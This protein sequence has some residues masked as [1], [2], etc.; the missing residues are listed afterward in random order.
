MQLRKHV[1]ALCVAVAA[2]CF[3]AQA[4]EGAES[5]I[6]PSGGSADRSGNDKAPIQIDLA[7]DMI[8]LQKPIAVTVAADNSPSQFKLVHSESAKSLAVHFNALNL[9]D[10]DQLVLRGVQNENYTITQALTGGFWSR[11]IAG[12][13]VIIELIPSKGVTAD[14]HAK[15]GFSVSIDG[16]KYMTSAQ[17]EEN[18]GSDDSQPAKCFMTTATKD[19]QAYLKAQA[20]A[21]VVINGSIP[22]SGA[23]LGASGYFLTASHCIS[24]PESAKEAIIEFGAESASCSDDSKIQLGS[25]GTDFLR[26]SELYAVNVELDYAILKLDQSKNNVVSKYGFLKLRAAGA[27]NGEEIFIAHHP[28][29]YA[30]RVSMVNDNK[31]ITAQTGLTATACDGNVADQVGYLADTV[32][33]SS[34]APVISSTDFT[35]VSVHRCGGCTAVGSNSGLNARVISDDLKKQGKDL[36]E[37]Y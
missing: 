23:I 25:Q 24:T 26:N 6:L 37:F 18:C 29:A 28:N 8:T 10:G 12:K 7:P 14:E 30:K 31:S 5:V 13:Y 21:R 4:Q 35:V 27:T 22:C 15:R 1:T 9:L 11:P 36:A 2:L 17:N 33:G 19:V 16:Y 34:G 3:T 32:G 20:V